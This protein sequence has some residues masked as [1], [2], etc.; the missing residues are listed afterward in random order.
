LRLSNKGKVIKSTK[1]SELLACTSMMHL[2]SHW[3]KSSHHSTHIER[4]RDSNSP[5]KHRLDVIH[6]LLLVP[7]LF[8]KISDHVLFLDYMIL[9]FVILTL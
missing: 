3:A 2:I 8:S 7:Q 1:V 5:I 4:I 9:L 6:F